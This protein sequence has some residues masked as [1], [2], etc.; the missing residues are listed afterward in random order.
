MPKATTRA[1]VLAKLRDMAKKNEIIIGAG[2]GR[3]N[4]HHLLYA[5]T[6]QLSI[7]GRILNATTLK[8][9]EQYQIVLN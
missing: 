4:F 2:A 8:G 1:E 7:R 6:G 9:K 5:F 3:L